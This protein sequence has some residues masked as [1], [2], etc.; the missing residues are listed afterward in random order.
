MAT[1]L[2]PAASCH[3]DWFFMV[4]TFTLP[5]WLLPA[6]HMKSNGFFS[7]TAAL[8]TANVFLSLEAVVV[9]GAVAAPGA[10]IVAV[11]IAAGAG[12][13]AVHVGVDVDAAVVIAVGVAV[14]VAVAMLSCYAMYAMLPLLCA[15]MNEKQG[16]STGA[17][18]EHKVIWCQSAHCSVLFSD[19]AS[20]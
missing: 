5:S 7:A 19:A 18:R 2:G 10:G 13:A 8:N 16:L 14:A 15:R 17:S 12:A 6:K 4:L 20:T 3:H 1:H 9:P 11:A